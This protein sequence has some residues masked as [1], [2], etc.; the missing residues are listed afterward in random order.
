VRT[1]NRTFRVDGRGAPSQS[2]SV[3]AHRPPR[4]LRRVELLGQ[5]PAGTL[6]EAVARYPEVS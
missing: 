5:A 3:G 2:A 4:A 6:A 1:T